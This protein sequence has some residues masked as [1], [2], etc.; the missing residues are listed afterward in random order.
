MYNECNETTK[1]SVDETAIECCGV[2][3]SDCVFLSKEFSYLELEKGDSLTQ[4]LEVI[5][6]KLQELE[7]NPLPYRDY[8]CTLTQSLTANPTNST[9]LSTFPSTVTV[10]FT[11][12]NVGEYTCTFSQPVLTIVDTV[13]IMPSNKPT[14]FQVETEV[15]STTSVTIKTY[16]PSGVLTDGLLNKTPI[17]IRSANV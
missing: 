6:D 4:T 1:P 9:P 8:A 12:I 3:A 2:Y 7:L 13:V 16:N 10:T 17:L 14:L 11:Y 5:E 15:I